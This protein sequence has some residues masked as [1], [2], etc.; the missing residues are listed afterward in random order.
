MIE[1]EKASGLPFF[2]AFTGCDAVSAFWGK[3]KKSAWQLW[4]VCNQAPATYPVLHHSWRRRPAGIGKICGG[5]VWQIKCGHR[6]DTTKPLC[7]QKDGIP[8]TNDP[9]KEHGK[10][11]AYQA[12]IIWGQA[13][14]PQPDVGTPANWECV[15][16][17]EAWH[18]RWTTFF[19]RLFFFSLK[20]RGFLY[21]HFLTNTRTWIIC[22]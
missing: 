13:T 15:Q 7:T 16:V 12:G 4:T 14:L 5:H 21:Q 1:P 11:A 10:H 2:H 3:G 20:G 18:V 17:G 6:C 19:I 22:I 8:P 9:L